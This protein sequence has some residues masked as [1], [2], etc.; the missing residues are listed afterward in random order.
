[1]KKIFFALLTSGLFLFLLILTYLVHVRYFEVK[2]LLYSAITDSLLAT[3]ATLIFLVIWKKSRIYTLFEKSQL[4]V[5]WLLVGY[6]IAISIPTIIDRYLSF[7][8]L[9][10]IQQRG[11]GIQL[12]KFEEVFTKEYVIEHRLV[13]VRLTEQQESGTIKIENGC[14]KLTKRGE[15]LAVFSQFFRANLLPK[16]RLLM[17]EYSDYLTHPFSN[18]NTNTISSY[19]CN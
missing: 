7:Y 6:V 19:Q 3:F 16:K 10:K 9:E 17:G 11:G 2:V 13:D 5:I 8:I 18:N 15:A 14:V 1:M 4:F 12:E